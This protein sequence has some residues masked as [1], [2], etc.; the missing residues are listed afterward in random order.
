MPEITQPA[1]VQ[2]MMPMA[3]TPGGEAPGVMNKDVGQP[4]SALLHLPTEA[5]TVLLFWK[6]K[7]RTDSC[8]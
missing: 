1:P 8:V 3:Q 4:V 6:S 5:M 7:G 2:L